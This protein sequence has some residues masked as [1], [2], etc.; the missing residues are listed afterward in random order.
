MFRYIKTV[1][2]HKC[3]RCSKGK[4][5]TGKWYQLTQITTMP[6]YCPVCGQKTEIEPGFYY[7]TGYVSY[8]LSVAFTVFT[9]AAWWLLIGFSLKD[10]RLF[11]WLGTNAVLL[12]LVQPWLMRTSRVLWLS[13]FF[14]RDDHRLFNQNQQTVHTDII[15][16]VSP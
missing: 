7:G 12:I 5:F 2:S 16:G 11:W 1:V 4:M 8:A 13:W 3:P 10:N 14:H 9:F 15:E 6:E